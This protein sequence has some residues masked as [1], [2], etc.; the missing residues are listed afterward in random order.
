MAQFLDEEEDPE[1]KLNV[2]LSSFTAAEY[3]DMYSIQRT[4]VSVVNKIDAYGNTPLH[5]AAQHDHVAVVAMLLKLGCPA[6]SQKSGATPLHRAS[7]SGAVSSMGLLLQHHA[8]LFAKDVS[9]NDQMTALHKAAAGGR[10]LAV[11][12]LIQTLRS[13]GDDSDGR[14]MLAEALEVKDSSGR[15]PLVIAKEFSVVQETEKGS[16]A[17]WDQVAGGEAD[18]IK[19]SRLLTAATNSL[20]I[21]SQSQTT[22]QL[23]SALPSEISRLRQGCVSSFE[24]EGVNIKSVTLPLQRRFQSVIQNSLDDLSSLASRNGASQRGTVNA[25]TAASIS[26]ATLA[27][28]P[29]SST[30]NIIP[31]TSTQDKNKE[32]SVGMKCSACGKVTV[33]LY[34]TKKQGQLACKACKR[35]TA[36][37]F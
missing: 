18:W 36:F 30:S 20:S 11:Q 17:R 33:A 14:S 15:T 4:G 13:R 12:L 19:C 2:R 28:N 10:Y 16:V 1:K 24:S 3:G 26:P 31:V 21:S 8:N 35:A 9:F 27:I 6:D 37:K 23:A 32:A 25:T 34:P 7:F 5:L 22:S 29:T